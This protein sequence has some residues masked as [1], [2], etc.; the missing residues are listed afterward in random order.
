A[1]MQVRPEV[2]IFAMGRKTRATHQK[3]GLDAKIPFT[4][5]RKHLEELI[6]DEG[7]INE[8]LYVHGNIRRYEM[9]QIL[10]DEGYE[11]IERWQYKSHIHSVEIPRKSISGI[12][13]YSPSAVEGFRQGTGFKEELPSLFAIGPTT[14]K[15]LKEYTKKKVVIASRPDTKTMLRMVSNHIFDGGKKV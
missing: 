11:V 12:M 4:E 13:F 2:Q 5:D 8:I 14:A 1:G 10:R 3:H 9:P 7:E 15:A 6:I